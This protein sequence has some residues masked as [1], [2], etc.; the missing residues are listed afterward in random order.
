M[1]RNMKNLF[2]LFALF[3]GIGATKAQTADQTIEWLQAKVPPLQRESDFGATIKFKDEFCEAAS[4]ITTSFP[5]RVVEVHVFKYSNIKSISY[6]QKELAGKL[7]YKI[8][9]TG[10]FQ[11]NKIGFNNEVTETKNVE[12]TDFIFN[13][14]VEKEEILRIVKALKHLATL[15]G[16]KL[17]N[18]NLF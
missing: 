15:K 5:I 14:S 3:L 6:L 4:S 10:N 18:D 13:A 17:I 1:A 9:I 2:I 7:Y 11:A 12:T 8:I 16:A